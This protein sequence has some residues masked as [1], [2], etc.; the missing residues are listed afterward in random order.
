MELLL[1]EWMGRSKEG[2]HEVEGQGIVERS[3]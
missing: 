3:K 1:F 2:K